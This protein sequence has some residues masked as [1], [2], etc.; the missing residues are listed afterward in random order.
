MKSFHIIIGLF[1]FLFGFIFGLSISYKHDT[2]L[3]EMSKRTVLGYLNNPKLESFNDVLYYTNKTSHNGGEVGYVCGFVSD[4]DDFH[5]KIE[6]KKFIVKTYSKPDG[7]IN[8]SIPVIEG[9]D[10]FDYQGG[11]GK[12]WERYCTTS[13]GKPASLHLK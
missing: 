7:T 13:N 5:Q 3:I 11:I 6:S 12:L 9:I 1:L 10:E 2:N 8:I 4:H